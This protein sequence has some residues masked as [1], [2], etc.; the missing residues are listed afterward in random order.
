MDDNPKIWS[1]ISL[2]SAGL[3]GD[4]EAEADAMARLCAITYLAKEDSLI[5]HDLSVATA[6]RVFV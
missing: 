6:A 1:L 3:A 5:T 4:I 2:R